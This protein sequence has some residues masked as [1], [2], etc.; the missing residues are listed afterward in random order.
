M[1]SGSIQVETGKILA[2]SRQPVKP[3]LVHSEEESTISTLTDS[4]TEP[5]KI[6]RSNSFREIKPKDEVRPVLVILIHGCAHSRSY[7]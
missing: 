2:P 1:I 3:I 5:L 4:V 6:I 7:S